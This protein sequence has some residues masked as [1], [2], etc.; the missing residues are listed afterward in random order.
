MRIGAEFVLAA[1][2][3]LQEGVPGSTTPMLSRHKPPRTSKTPKLCGV[4]V[5]SG[6][7]AK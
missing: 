4:H 2:Q 5:K 7:D 1:A 6:D 3:V